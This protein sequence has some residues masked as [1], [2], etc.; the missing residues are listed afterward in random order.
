MLSSYKGASGHRSVWRQARVVFSDEWPKCRSTGV[1]FAELPLRA[2]PVRAEIHPFVA[3][4]EIA[5]PSMLT[6]PCVASCVMCL[7]RN[8]PVHCGRVLS[9]CFLLI[10]LSLLL[11]S[12]EPPRESLVPRSENR[13]LT[14]VAGGEDDPEAHAQNHNLLPRPRRGAPRESGAALYS[15]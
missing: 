8:I 13:G 3:S 7:S 4:V 14:L 6:L 9:P 15:R 5:M 2:M 12:S 10:P 11:A 1:C